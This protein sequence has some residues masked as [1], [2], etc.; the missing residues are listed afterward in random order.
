MFNVSFT[1]IQ[2]KTLSS[3]CSQSLVYKLPSASKRGFA[4]SYFYKAHYNWNRLPLS[5]RE[6]VR[7]RKFKQKL[8]QSAL[9][10]F[11]TSDSE[12]GYE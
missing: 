7:Q 5:L 6:I 3:Y 9:E 4:N 1:T 12:D 8:L 10:E 11:V 2:S